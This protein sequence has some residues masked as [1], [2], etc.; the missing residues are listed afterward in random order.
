LNYK[1]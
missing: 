1:H